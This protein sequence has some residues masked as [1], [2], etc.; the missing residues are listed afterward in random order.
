MNPSRDE[1]V[2]FAARTRAP[3]SSRTWPESFDPAAFGDENAAELNRTAMQTAESEKRMR[4]DIDSPFFPSEEQCE[5]APC[6][7]V[8]WLPA[9]CL[10]SAPSRSAARNSGSRL[11]DFVAVYSCEGSGGCAPHFPSA[12]RRFSNEVAQTL[13]C[14]SRARSISSRDHSIRW[15]LVRF[16]SR[17]RF[18]ETHRLKSVLPQTKSLCPARS[19]EW[20]EPGRGFSEPR[21]RQTRHSFLRRAEH[22]IDFGQ[23]SWLSFAAL[24]SLSVS[25]LAFPSR[26][27]GEGLASSRTLSKH[28]SGGTARDSHPLPYSPAAFVRSRH[29]QSV[30]R[31]TKR[32]HYSTRLRAL[33]TAALAGP[34]ILSRV[35]KHTRREPLR[36]WPRASPNT[37][38]G[39]EQNSSQSRNAHRPVPTQGNPPHHS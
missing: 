18:R 33:Q 12:R 25:T 21:Q 2:T 23:V 36:L 35:L 11:A 6:E 4:R 10:L 16:L 37:E 31:S 19:N 26:K 13:V 28:H 20:S 34:L 15:I 29:P 5:S 24:S 1:I 17:C 9:S 8:S 27:A 38:V 14:V 30:Q 22:V 39:H 32:A 7:P 3:A